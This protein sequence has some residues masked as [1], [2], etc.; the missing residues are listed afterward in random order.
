MMYRREGSRS[1]SECR[2][3]TNS[4]EA[5]SRSLAT[6]PI[7]DMIRMLATTYG[8]SVTST[9]TLLIGE[10]TG[11]ITYGTTYIVRPRIAPSSSA[12][13]LCFAAFGSIQ[14]FVGPAS[15]FSGEQIYV[16]CSVRATSFG[17]LRCR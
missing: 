2:P 8:L 1:P 10:L 7:R 13:T 16:R 12:P 11:P 3:G 6:L 14:L 15:S 17:L 5:P 9:P 4:L